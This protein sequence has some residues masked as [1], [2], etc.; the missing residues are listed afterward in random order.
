MPHTVDHVE[1]QAH[2]LA[3]YYLY[4]A[5]T[6]VVAGWF[7]LVFSPDESD[8]F[9]KLLVPFTT[10]LVARSWNGAV[11]VAPPLK[12]SGPPVPSKKGVRP[13]TQL[14]LVLALT[15]FPVSLTVLSHGLAAWEGGAR[16][17]TR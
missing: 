12:I 17:A 5:S 1:L 14:A 4:C 3:H 8:L 15:P 11:Y 10:M 6:P 2:T 16:P 9:A 13:L 7:G